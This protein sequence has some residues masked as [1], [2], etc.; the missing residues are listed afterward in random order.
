METLYGILQYDD[1][2]CAEYTKMIFTSYEQALEYMR[3]HHD[4]SDFACVEEWKFSP[5][6]DRYLTGERYYYLD[7]K[8]L[9]NNEYWNEIERRKDY[10]N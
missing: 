4:D 1:P 8:V 7:G 2:Y 10:D 5:E 6:K 9:T 3:L